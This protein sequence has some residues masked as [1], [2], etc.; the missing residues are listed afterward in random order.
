MKWTSGTF[1]QYP[2]LLIKY[3]L[4]LKILEG[5]GGRCGEVTLDNENTS[6]AEIDKVC[7]LMALAVTR[8]GKSPTSLFGNLPG[9]Q[10]DF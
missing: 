8:E 5:Y 10:Q 7:V 4:R 2:E 9:S 3:F 6:Q 1:H